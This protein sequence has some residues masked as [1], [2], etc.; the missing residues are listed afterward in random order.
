VTP[1]RPANCGFRVSWSPAFAARFAGAPLKGAA[2]AHAGR[3]VRG[4]AV[5]TAEGIEGGAIYA[6]SAGLRDALPATLTVDLK[7]DVAE[8][9]LAARLAAMRPG[10]S[11]ATRLRRLGLAPV[12]A[13]LLRESAGGPLPRE[14]AAL[15]ARIRAARLVLADTAGMARAIS[16]A[17]GLGFAG[18]D[19]RLMLTAAPGL[20]AAGEM[21]DWEAPTG[22][23]LLQACLATGRAAGAGALAW[24]AEGGRPA[25]PP[26]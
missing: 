14:P 25:W 20:F 10:L 16:T 8:A 15:A 5:V 6:L 7:P 11:L 4:E 9:A 23:Y 19:D 1:L 2:F 22:G 3:R 12:A 24:L 17:G 13:G 18:L 26:G 21:L